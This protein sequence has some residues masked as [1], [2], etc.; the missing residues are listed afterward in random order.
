MKKLMFILLF[1]L[2]CNLSNVAEA[3]GPY[4]ICDP[5]AGITIY[6]ISGA[7]WVSATVPAQTN[8]SIKMDMANSP[9]GTFTLAV[10]A[11]RPGLQWPAEE[12]SAPVNFTYTRPSPPQVPAGLGLIP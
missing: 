1:L 11:C 5:Q 2:L 6:Q 10:K 12:C 9:T 8:G 7:S 3:A 4:L